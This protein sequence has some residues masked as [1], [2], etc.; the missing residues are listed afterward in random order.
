MVRDADAKQIAKWAA[1]GDVATPESRGLARATGWPSS[2]SQTGGNL[3]SREVFNQLLRELTALAVELNTRGMLDWDSGITY[4]HPAF[5]VGT[6]GNLYVSVQ[7]SQGVNPVTDS[8]AGSWR[9]YNASGWSPAYSLHTDGSRE[10]LQLE[11]WFG[12]AGSKPTGVGDYVGSDGLTTS[13]AS[14]KNLRGPAGPTGPTGGR[15]PAGRDGAG[16]IP[17]GTVIY[18]N[19]SS[20]PSGFTRLSSADVRVL[21]EFQTDNAFRSGSGWASV[22]LGQLNYFSY[23]YTRRTLYAHRKT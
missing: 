12:G 1:S 23:R 4:V 15:G 16:G 8:A 18:T 3:P 21:T 22:P 19:S 9:P 11:D 5:V 2:Y 6:D 7:N 17:S 13:L 14:A 10:V 20:S